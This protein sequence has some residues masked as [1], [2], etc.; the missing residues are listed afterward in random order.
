MIQIGKII[1]Q[2]IR[3]QNFYIAKIKVVYL[4]TV[5]PDP[6][7]GDTYNCWGEWTPSPKKN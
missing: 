5:F 7:W 2:A 6:E 1:V 3:K 4:M